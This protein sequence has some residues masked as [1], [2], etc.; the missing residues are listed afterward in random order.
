VGMVS[1]NVFS[2]RLE[3]LGAVEAR[4]EVGGEKGPDCGAAEAFAAE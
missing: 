2:G 3:G 4:G 1:E